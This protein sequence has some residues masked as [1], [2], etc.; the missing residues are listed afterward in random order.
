MYTCRY[1]CTGIALD[2]ISS[3]IDIC[4]LRNV[5]KGILEDICE[6]KARSCGTKYISIHG[7]HGNAT[8]AMTCVSK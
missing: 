4:G 5:C 2:V 6:F 1:T 8:A 7:K 3:D